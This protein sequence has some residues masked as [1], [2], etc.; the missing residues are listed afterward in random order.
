MMLLALAEVSDALAATRSRLG[1]VD[2]LA[3]CLRELAPNERETGV[4]WLTGN[5]PSGPLGLGPATVHELRDVP[6][7]ADATLTI[8]GARE[9][10]ESLKEIGGRGS[11]ARRQAAL[12]DLF[13]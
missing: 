2:L 13:A 6:A 5:L 3:R 12:R 4:A 1:K 9:R 8:A 11:A 7:A 10:L